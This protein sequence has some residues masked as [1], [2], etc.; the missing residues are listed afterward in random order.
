ML[1]FVL[2][3]TAMPFSVLP[4]YAQDA[5]ETVQDA[6]ETVQD[7]QEA[8]QDAN[9]TDTFSEAEVTEEE[10]ESDFEEDTA[11]DEEAEESGGQ[12]EKSREEEN[13]G[14]EEA[15]EVEPAASDEDLSRE[16]EISGNDSS[17][18]DGDAV[19]DA[20]QEA[21]TDE[22]AGSD[23]DTVTTEPSAGNE[24]S[25]ES[26][27]TADPVE[28]G[29]ETE[30]PEKAAQEPD[31]D[32]EIT[33]EPSEETAVVEPGSLDNAEIYGGRIWFEINDGR[34]FDDGTYTFYL[35]TEEIPEA[36]DVNL[37]VVHYDDNGLVEAYTKGQEYDFDG[38]SLT[39]YGDRIAQRGYR[40]F[41]LEV[42]AVS[43]QD[44]HVLCTNRYGGFESKAVF[45]DY[46]FEDDRD[47]L[48]GWH[49]TINHWENVYVEN[50]EHPDGWITGYEV[51]GVEIVSQ[52]PAE[53]GKDVLDIRM[54]Y[55]DDDPSSDNY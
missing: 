36:Y 2:A 17:E 14:A 6:Q 7:A 49:D 26:A 42:E 5:Q 50:M 24:E 15:A 30:S 34:I 10:G 46:E 22:D 33:A 53:N 3:V 19:N 9:E 29:A 55:E 13:T 32:V 27:E 31:Q 38:T 40:W 18:E 16:E 8:V 45:A 25:A 1:A 20:E 47:L 48:P 43:T 4:A 21:G 51:T 44:G 12:E 28:T 37:V 35:Y 52:D 39:L 54:Y 23:A 41:G 11:G